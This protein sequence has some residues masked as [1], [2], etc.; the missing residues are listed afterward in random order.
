[1]RWPGLAG[2]APPLATCSRIWKRI[3]IRRNTPRSPARSLYLIGFVRMRP[4]GQQIAL[5]WIYA[6][7]TGN[8]WHD[9][10]T[11]GFTSYVFFNPRADCAA[12]VLLNSGPNPLLSPDVIGEHIRQRLSGEPAISLDTVLVPASSGFRGVLRSF[13]AYWFTMLAAGVFV[14]GAVLGVQ[15][16]AALTLPRRLFLRAIGIS[17]NGGHLL[18][19]GRVLSAAW[20]RRT[21]RPRHRLDMARDSVAAVVLVSRPVPA[22]ERIHAS[23]AGAAGAAGMDWLGGGGLRSSRALHAFLLAHSAQDRGGTRYRAG[24]APADV[25]CP[26]SGPSLRPRSGNSPCALWRAASSIA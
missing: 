15:G 1:M 6:A 25:G 7:D 19:R 2:F 20:L 13:G 8:Y 17:A 21:G 14:Y 16:L 4:E 5:A 9:G 10:G 11:A 12:V 22:I 23:G 26:D 18:D 24:L 3:C